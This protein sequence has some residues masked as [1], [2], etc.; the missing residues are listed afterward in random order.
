LR[1]YKNSTTPQVIEQLKEILKNLL[2]PKNTVRLF[3]YKTALLAHCYRAHRFVFN[4]QKS[5]SRPIGRIFSHPSNH[6]FFG[7]YDITPF[8]VDE[9]LLLA[10][11]V[12]SGKQISS[13]WI[14]ATV[15][16]YDL[17][18]EK[19][20]FYEIGSTKTWCWQQG[21]RLQWYPEENNRV[22][23][24]NTMVDE[25]YGCIV[26]D[27]FSKKT[28][29]HYNLPI[30]SVSKNGK[31]GLSLNFS[32]LQRLRPGYGYYVLPDKTVGEFMPK[33]SGIV[34]LDMETGEKSFLFSVNDIANLKATGTMQDA[35]HYFNHLLY[36]PEGSRFLCV[37][38][39]VKEGR[40]YSRL[41][42]ADRDGNHVYVMNNEGHSSHYCWKSNY[43]IL[44]YATYAETGM[45]YY[46]CKDMSENRTIIG[47]GKLTEDGH[48]SFF[49]NGSALITDTYP[50]KYRAQSL[51]L[52]NL[53][54]CQLK[55]LNQ[56]Y[57]PSKFSG[58]NRCDLHPKL[59]PTGTYVCID[60]VKGI[61][62]F[63]AY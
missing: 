42:T 47:R 30:Y 5:K 51:L 17:A 32:R 57:I 18:D 11:H 20:S 41:I 33:K 28:I 58:E 7:Y 60:N 56:F 50:D 6:V 22:V 61:N 24:Y 15:G 49:P 53:N 48:P 12:S 37:H 34:R 23:L 55:T 26:K 8:S 19:R 3:R 1:N 4:Y 54:N 38:L 40:R 31:W 39:W 14:K 62:D 21:C 45:H 27:I 46:L 25:N 13:P 52:F 16:F 10:M 2:G 43:E 9:N 36:N 29:K 59:S 35:E 44:V 63:A